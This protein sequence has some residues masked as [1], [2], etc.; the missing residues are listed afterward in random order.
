MDFFQLII[1]LAQRLHYA[2]LPFIFCI[3]AIV[4][5][6]KIAPKI[7]LVDRP[8]ERK[9]HVGEIPVVGGV[10]IFLSITLFCIAL[11]QTE[12][13]VQLILIS[14]IIVTTGLIDDI[15]EL[16]SI[17]RLFI[18]IT[19]AV[20][21]IHTT[22][23]QISYLGNVLARGDVYLM[24]EI[25]YVF[26][27]LC[28]VGVIN[29]INMIDGLDGLA[30]SILYLSFSGLFVLAWLGKTFHDAALILAAT[31][32]LLAFLVFNSR[33]FLKKAKIFLGDSGSMFLG[34]LLCWFFLILSQN[35]NPSLSPIAAG[36]IFGLPLADTVSVMVRRISEQ[37]SPLNAGRDH[38]HHR[39]VD[40]GISVNASV[41]ILATI[42][43]ILVTGGVLVS[44]N[45]TLE[46]YAFWLF[47]SIVMAHHFVSPVAIK[48][49]T[50]QNSLS[51]V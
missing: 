12:Y 13:N 37:R 17:T 27:I 31:M 24:P 10:S 23:Y 49:W 35:E 50:K 18:Q 46:P 19:V 8:T 47:V 28:V 29:S 34:F 7:G 41:G 5:L 3:A 21:L 44:L 15:K 26:T 22:G 11:S 32:S 43:L 45:R 1:F 36:W 9:Q 33:I 30:G 16:S 42:H 39:L 38:F 40:S 48:K 2:V 14:F 25:G 4:V 6:M 51:L 20:I